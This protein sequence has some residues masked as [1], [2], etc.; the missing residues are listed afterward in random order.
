MMAK[1]FTS[2]EE[3][4][5]MYEMSTLSLILDCFIWLGI[6]GFCS[7][8]IMGIIIQKC[9]SKWIMR[10]YE[11]WEDIKLP[12]LIILFVAMSILTAITGYLRISTGTY[13]WR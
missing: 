8:E 6:I 7:F 4:F 5:G 1:I 2:L 10:W 3:V 12:F 13:F 11:M 9:E